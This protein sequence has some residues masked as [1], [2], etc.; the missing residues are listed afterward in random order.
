MKNILLS[1]VMLTACL[2]SPAFAQKYYVS[3]QGDDSNDGMT[4]KTAWQTVSRVNK[5]AFLPGD[6]VLFA[7]GDKF[8][9]PLIVRDSGQSDALITFGSYG[10][11]AKPLIE[12]A[13]KR[14]AVKVINQ[15]YIKF[16]NIWVTNDRTQSVSGVPDRESYGFLVRNKGKDTMKGV[17]FDGVK[18]SNVFP[19]T[20]SGIAHNE[21]RSA[22]IYVENRLNANPDD[23][24]YIQDVVI[25]NSY[26]TRIHKLGVWVRGRINNVVIKNNRF[27]HNG[28]SGV[29]MSGVNKGLLER[30]DIMHSGSSI[31]K[32]MVKRGSGAWFFNCN[33]VIAQYNTV[34]HA[35]GPMDTAGI[36]ID[37]GNKNL[38][39]Q[40]NF[41]F[42]N[43][44]NF[45]EILGGNLNV[46]YRYNVDIGSG[47]RNITGS[48]LLVGDY[49]YNQD[50]RDRRSEKVYIYN[51]TAYVGTRPNGSAIS[52]GVVL[53]VKK[54]YIYNN[55]FH[56][57][58]GGKIGFKRFL[59][60]AD[61]LTIYNNNWFGAI[62]NKLVARD[63]S[64]MQSNSQ[65][66]LPGGLSKYDYQLHETSPMLNRSAAN[67]E[68]S[69][70]F[71]GQGIFES[72]TEKATVDI[73]NNPVDNSVSGNHIGAFN[74]TPIY[75]YQA[76]DAEITGNA[77]VNHCDE[78]MNKEL[79]KG[80]VNESKITFPDVYA[81]AAGEY[82]LVVYYMLTSKV[83][84]D[85]T[86]NGVRQVERFSRTG[87]WCYQGGAMG[88][89]TLNV[90]L[91]A[92]MNTITFGRINVIDAIETIKK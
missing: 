2:C 15:N 36:H 76:E 82:E 71:A 10:K 52:T 3:S 68:P 13:Q 87:Q 73:F 70:P 12:G 11:G 6:K 55:I 22:G 47:W 34:G 64:G 63:A 17:Y 91:Q 50:G 58:K 67:P 78:A 60:K 65:F 20:Y 44:G 81:D 21:I 5:A 79:V 4:S 7:A 48:T 37:I 24:G 84:V 92:G 33:N 25:K 26:F 49:H 74:G 9:G 54:A 18:V 38:I 27:V 45:V 88:A 61:D 86:V 1:I 75:T 43:Q 57:T 59:I 19:V 72:I 62:N 56:A 32:R 28:G 83:K 23:I 30:N 66:W 42:D 89:K 69:F 14:A 53:K 39:I 35:R 16:K 40:Y 41:T 31:D 90:E 8:T 77:T 29:V 51:N 85:V 80:V 46:A